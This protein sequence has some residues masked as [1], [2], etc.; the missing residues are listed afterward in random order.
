MKRLIS[1]W[2]LAFA[3]ICAFSSSLLSEETPYVPP[4]SSGTGGDDSG[5]GHPWGGDDNSTGLPGGDT[6]FLDQPTIITGIPGIDFVF[7]ILKREWMLSH[8][9]NR[10]T[11]TTP[12]QNDQTVYR[13]Q[14]YQ[15]ISSTTRNRRLTTRNERLQPR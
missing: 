2:L 4:P 3:L 5:D 7:F 6:G 15:P 13:S 1:I 12:A 11:I 10:S 14:N 8:I 9:S